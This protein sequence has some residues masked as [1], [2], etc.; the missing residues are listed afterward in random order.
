MP[1]QI[2]RRAFAAGAAGMASS[3]SLPTAAFAKD[4][5][6]AVEWGPP[7]INGTKEVAARYGKADIAW[8]LHQ[9][10]SAAILAKI[11][12]TWPNTP[13]DMVDSWTV[14]ILSMVREGWA[15][16]VTLADA[17]NLADVPAALIPKDKDGN[18]KSI[19]RS[20]NGAYFAY[21][22]E[23]CPIEI[24]T[25]EDLL[26]PKLKGQIAW[27]SATSNTCLQVVALA[28]ARG[29]SE[30]DMEPG[31]R[32][33][34]EIAKAG[35]IGR[36]WHGPA[37]AIN[38]LTSG[39]TSVTFFD[40]GTQSDVAKRFKIKY[41]TKTHESLKSFLW[42]EG[43]TILGNSK[44]KKAAFDFANFTI[45]PEMSEFFHHNHLRMP[46]A[47][48]KAKPTPGLDHLTFN[49]DERTKYSYVP[50]YEFIVTKVSEWI[51]RFETDIVPNL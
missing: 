28:L 50:D 33:L 8:E 49:D 48:A 32:F 3:M 1:K 5:L 23:R 21:L 4:S 17:P 24:K 43:W 41:L 29:G 38:S 39:E 6:T 19:P 36:V 26:S 35:N 9:G 15:Q 46:S 34:R 51:K 11:K 37:D 7:W 44:N 20:I 2:T 47:N 30:R 12:G 18:W 31:W 10:G 22:P 13:Y 40:Q 16:T 14:P 27:P 25:V 45:S 42:T